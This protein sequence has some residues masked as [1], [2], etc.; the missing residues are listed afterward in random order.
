MK[1]SKWLFALLGLC[2]LLGFRCL[3]RGPEDAQAEA[4]PLLPPA[5]TAL[6]AYDTPVE[7]PLHA[8][9]RRTDSES[10]PL[11]LLPGAGSA[12]PS[13][14]CDRNG[15]LLLGGRWSKSAYASCP[16]EARFG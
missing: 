7:A 16:P 15:N 6:C 9:P 12:V 5:E 4:A 2:M 3:L 14:E 8:P 10:E 11:A 1:L 13:P